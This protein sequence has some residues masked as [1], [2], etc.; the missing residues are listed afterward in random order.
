MNIKAFT[1]IELLIVVAII[2]ILAAIAVPNFSQALVRA[3][4][5]NVQAL[6]KT[7]EISAEQYRMD[8]NSLPPH[9][10]T[11]QQN[12]WLTTPVAYMSERPIDIFQDFHGKAG[13]TRGGWS[14][15]SK[16]AR[17]GCPHYEF[18]ISDGN[19]VDRSKAIAGVP[20][21]D[22]WIY[23]IG[24]DQTWSSEHAPGLNILYDISNGLYSNGDIVKFRADKN[25]SLLRM[26]HPIPSGS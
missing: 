3:R 20:D 11:P 1:L 9:F 8:N 7:M 26:L 23:T 12:A 16:N 21:L 2:G 25:P 10:N 4:V 18:I 5:A 6:L 22:W 14:E 13:S 24:P 15:Y 17:F 19:A